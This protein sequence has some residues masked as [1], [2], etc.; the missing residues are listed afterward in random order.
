MKKKRAKPVLA[1]GIKTKYGRL[2]PWAVCRGD[3]KL[4]VLRDETIARVEIREAK[5]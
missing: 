3:A 4:L 5:K 2:R 1:W